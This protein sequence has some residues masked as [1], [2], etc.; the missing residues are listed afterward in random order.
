MR[1]KLG[2]LTALVCLLAAGAAYA[3]GP[4]TGGPNTYTGG[5]SVAGA[6][7]T[8]VKP[9]AVAWTE[10][11]GMGSTTTGNVG[12]P[13]VD[14]KTSIY[15]LKAPNARYFATCTANKI[16]GNNG[17]NGKWN[18]VCPKASLVGN[19]TVSAVLVPSSLVGPGTPC[20]LNLLVYNGGPGKLTYFFTVPTT[21]TGCAGLATGAAAAWTGAVSQ[22]GK[23][24]VTNTP[25]PA[26]VAYNAG[27]T[28]L[29]GSL[30]TEK[31]TFRKLTV[32]KGT[33]VYP[34][35]ESIGCM[36]HSRPYSI[37]Y[38]ATE[39]NTGS[40]TV[41]SGTVKASASC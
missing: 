11:Y 27:N 30:V 17:N 6:V 5:M 4:V 1:K 14:I 32:K 40:P 34:F 3:A 31:L 19:G 21:G 28:G 16:N 36:K 38:T 39:S 20:A 24:L 29:F 13:L 12:A 23:N 35:I 25:E 15:G 10:T 26:D 9:A 37:T 2:A 41:G 22:A 7:G 33:K 8:T 18:G